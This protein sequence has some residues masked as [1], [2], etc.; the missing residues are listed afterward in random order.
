[1]RADDDLITQADAL[2][3][4]YRSFV[5]RPVSP[6]PAE[7]A[8]VSAAE[9]AETIPL[10]TE[11]VSDTATGPLDPDALLAPLQ[12]ELET[13]LAAWLDQALPTALAAATPQLLAALEADARQTL[14][15][16]LLETLKHGIT[17]QKL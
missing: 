15:P 10:L 5:A 6:P 3:R 12:G 2:M 1:M 17:R 4:R 9:T 8:P 13:A 11:V 16:N 7:P 14:L